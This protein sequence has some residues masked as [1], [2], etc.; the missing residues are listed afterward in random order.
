MARLALR[1]D[2]LIL[3]L[4][5]A[6]TVDERAVFLDPVGG[7]E[8]EH[9]CLDLARVD[10]RGAPELRA[11]GRQRVHDHQPFEVRQRLLNLVGVRTDAGGRHAGQDYALHLALQ[12]LVV[13]RHPRRVLARL[14]HVVE[15]EL[16]GFGGGI[17]V[18]GLEGADH[19]LAVVGPEKVPRVRIRLLGR[20]LGHIVVKVLLARRWDLQI[21]REDLPR[22]CV[23]GVALDVGMAALGIHAPTRPAHVAK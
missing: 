4:R 15:R 22:D 1:R 9:L 16:I 13:D 3:P 8:H 2:D 21:A 5:P 18:P 19:E 11:R 6:T 10:A 12:R 17:A 7:R 20:A 14:G 23:V